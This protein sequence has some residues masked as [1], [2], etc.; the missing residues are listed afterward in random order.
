MGSWMLQ[1][2]FEAKLEDKTKDCLLCC[3]FTWLS[4]HPDAWCK[5]MQCVQ[6]LC[7]WEV[8][9][10]WLRKCACTP[11]AMGCWGWQGTA[12]CKPW[13]KQILQRR[14]LSI[15]HC[16]GTGAFGHRLWKS[17]LLNAPPLYCLQGLINPLQVC[18]SRLSP[19][20]KEGKES[21]LGLGEFLLCICLLFIRRP[22]QRVWCLLWQSTPV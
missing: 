13:N 3:V 18:F 9:L 16:S 5:E 22:Q 11:V 17:E 6:H 10:S 14:N 12:N 21:R 15:C 4:W 7:P 19:V 2:C 1:R 8:Q 20:A